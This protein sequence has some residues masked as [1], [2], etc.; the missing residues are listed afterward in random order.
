MEKVDQV[1]YE[2]IKAARKARDALKATRR[3]GRKGHLARKIEAW[4]KY[5]E[6]KRDSTDKNFD[7]KKNA[8]IEREHGRW[9]RKSAKW[10]ARGTK[11]GMHWEIKSAKFNSRMARGFG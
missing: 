4:K 5:F 8:R 2:I 10:S 1:K 3:F 9:N 6:R 11:W 7:A